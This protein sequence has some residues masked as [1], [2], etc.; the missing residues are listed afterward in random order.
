[1]SVATTSTLGMA[2]LRAVLDESLGGHVLSRDS[3]G[4][5]H[6]RAAINI[7]ARFH[8]VLLRLSALAKY[9]ERAQV[10]AAES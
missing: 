10:P 4:G 3:G 5:G 2:R 7:S 8:H 1:M 9:G 6:E